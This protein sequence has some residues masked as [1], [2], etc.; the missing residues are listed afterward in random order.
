MPMAMPTLMEGREPDGA[1]GPRARQISDKY[2]LGERAA[3]SGESATN[4][5]DFQTELTFKDPEN[6]ERTI[7]AHWHGKISRRFYRL[8]FEWPITKGMPRLKV[9][10][11]G[12]KITKG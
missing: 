1:E 12:P 4:Q 6:T 2:F 11:L 7:F 10:Y 8:H 9:L 5:R 3:F